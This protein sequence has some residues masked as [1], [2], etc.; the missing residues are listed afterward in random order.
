MGSE[1][2]FVSHT[3]LNGHHF[4]WFHSNK[5]MQEEIRW[6]NV[7]VGCVYGLQPKLERIF[8]YALN[9]WKKYRLQSIFRVNDNMFLFQFGE[10]EGYNQ[11]LKDRPF[12][13]DNR[14]F[15]LNK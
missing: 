13:F 14:P 11:L 8:V 2:E 12:T 1:L 6:K 5:V 15:I 4:V 9:W 3:V 10:D 7:L